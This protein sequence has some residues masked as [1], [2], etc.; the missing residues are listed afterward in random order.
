[1]TSTPS[2][3]LAHANKSAQRTAVAQLLGYCEVLI[4]AGSLGEFHEP[5]MRRL[6]ANTLT[7]FDMRSR[8]EILASCERAIRVGDHQPELVRV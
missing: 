3:R 6:V 7:A 4:S 1:M 8:T 5:E 2:E